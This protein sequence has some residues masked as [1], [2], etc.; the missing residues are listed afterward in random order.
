MREDLKNWVGEFWNSGRIGIDTGAGA[1]YEHF[2]GRP[3]PP[4]AAGNPATAL[5]WRIDGPRQGDRT[6]NDFPACGGVSNEYETQRARYF[7]MRLTRI[8][9]FTTINCVDSRNH[10]NNQSARSFTIRNPL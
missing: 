3:C 5:L 9:C 10:N 6:R 7:G 8:G 2:A 1:G 4:V